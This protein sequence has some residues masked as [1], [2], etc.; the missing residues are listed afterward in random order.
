MQE[1]PLPERQL[2][3]QAVMPTKNCSAVISGGH[4]LKVTKH[5]LAALNFGVSLHAVPLIFFEQ[6]E[7]LLVSHRQITIGMK[8]G[9]S[10][11]RHLSWPSRRM[12]T[13][14]S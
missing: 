10:A 2:R 4:C 1:L 7:A 9:Q 3:R 13:A 12:F 14:S 6:R 5:Y 11:C 8:E